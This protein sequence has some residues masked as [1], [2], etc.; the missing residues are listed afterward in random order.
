MAKV[1]GF[2]D[3]KVAHWR[4]PI[5]RTPDQEFER[6]ILGIA[7]NLNGREFAREKVQPVTVAAGFLDR[8]ERGA[9]A[10]PFET[11]GTHANASATGAIV[12]HDR[13]PPG[14]VN[15]QAVGGEFTFRRQRIGR[16]RDEDSVGAC[17]LRYSGI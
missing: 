12:E 10:D 2:F 14:L 3:K 5:R 6:L 8:S 11:V 13:H 17:F 15:H 16:R 7:T 1:D 9:L 4:D